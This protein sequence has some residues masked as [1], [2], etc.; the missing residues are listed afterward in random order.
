MK[1]FS[2]KH[3]PGALLLSCLLLVPALSW[4]Q[5]D[6]DYQTN[7]P[8]VNFTLPAGWQRY[9]GAA[10]ADA[11]AAPSSA[12]GVIT[13]RNGHSAEV[14]ANVTLDQ[15]V[16]TNG[17]TLWLNTNGATLTLNDGQGD[18]LEIGAGGTLLH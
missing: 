10:W 8:V 17:G 4:G 12:N 5:A 15:T 9:N 14:T 6:G 11:D 3:A 1:D 13:I 2:A 16:I 18:D 7:A